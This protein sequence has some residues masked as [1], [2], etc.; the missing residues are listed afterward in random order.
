MKL[1]KLSIKRAAAVAKITAASTATAT[2]TVKPKARRACHGNDNKM[3]EAVEE[4]DRIKN[5]PN[6][7]K[8][9]QF[10]NSRGINPA[11]FQKYAHNDLVKR[12]VVGSKIGR[13]SL[14]TNNNAE[15]VIH[16]AIRAGSA[17]DGIT[18]NDIIHTLQKIQPE[19][20]PQQAKNY[21]QRT[22]KKK[23]KDMIKPRPVKAQED[24][25]K[26]QEMVGK[27]EDGDDNDDNAKRAVE[28]GIQKMKVYLE[29]LISQVDDIVDIDIG[30]SDKESV[31]I[32][33]VELEEATD[34]TANYA[35]I[36][37]KK[38]VILTTNAQLIERSL[39][40][41]GKDNNLWVWVSICSC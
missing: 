19:L 21:V 22:L 36:F 23:T 32:D 1:V 18:T 4:W 25:H 33:V 29:H 11:T 27:E 8:K 5:L 24:T 13:P 37:T 6:A 34:A 40:E 12:R 39:N 26:M 3:G 20:A 7:P 9:K 14:V 28:F 2:S 31:E 16:H 15:L 35:P 10:A 41:L 38:L 17:N 30:G